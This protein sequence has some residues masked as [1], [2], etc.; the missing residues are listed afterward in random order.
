MATFLL[1]LKQNPQR[2]LKHKTYLCKRLSAFHLLERQKR[3]TQHLVTPIV[4]T[5]SVLLKR[6]ITWCAKCLYMC[7]IV[8]K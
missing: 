8:A 7:Q 4:I 1:C 5:N 6:C 2:G 3:Q